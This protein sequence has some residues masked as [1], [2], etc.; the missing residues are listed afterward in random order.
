M[1]G[2]GRMLKLIKLFMFMF[3]FL[4]NYFCTFPLY[5]TF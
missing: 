4:N 3:F 5:N 1:F 2:L